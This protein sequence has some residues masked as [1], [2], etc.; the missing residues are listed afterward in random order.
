MDPGAIGETP[1]G[2]RH[3]LRFIGHCV[4]KATAR[5]TRDRSPEARAR[6]CAEAHR[7]FA[8][9]GSST[10]C[11]AHA[12]RQSPHAALRSGPSVSSRTALALAL[13]V[14]VVII[15]R[16]LAETQKPCQHLALEILKFFQDGE[17]QIT[18]LGEE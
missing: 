3:P 9:A 7:G 16:G 15:K 6:V 4:P 10:A 5:P 11:E 1:A 17:I 13:L 2:H 8:A 14:S 18:L 12:K